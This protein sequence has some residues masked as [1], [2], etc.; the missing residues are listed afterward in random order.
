MILRVLYEPFKTTCFYYSLGSGIQIMK[1]DSS[2]IKMTMG[3]RIQKNNNNN[4]KKATDI[5]L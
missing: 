4:K 3:V 2:Y 1:L 5:H